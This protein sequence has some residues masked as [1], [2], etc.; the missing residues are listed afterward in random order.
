MSYITNTNT[1]LLFAGPQSPFPAAAAASTSA[2]SLCATATGDAVQPYIP[3]F[4]WQYGRRNQALKLMASGIMQASTTATTCTF[5]FGVTSTGGGVITG[6]LNA[7]YTGPALT[8][9]T[10]TT[11]F[12][13]ILT[14]DVITLNVGW[15]TT[16]VST[17]VFAYGT[18]MIG[19]QTSTTAMS[20]YNGAPV[21]I[22]T[23]DN[24]VNQ[25][26]YGAIT[27]S[28]SSASNTATWQIAKLYGEN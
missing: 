1:E 6:T 26:L 13:W 2:Q 9:G 28:T 24:S 21:T 15:G 8:V 3:A 4:W 14:L 22:S 27:F 23:I 25:Y 7:L 17:Q 11:N 16:S 10:A 12:N 5:A 18:F 19:L 20:V